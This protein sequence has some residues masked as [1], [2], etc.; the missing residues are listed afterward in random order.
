MVIVRL[1]DLFFLGF[2]TFFFLW[3]RPRRR[4]ARVVNLLKLRTNKL[5]LSPCLQHKAL[6]R[7]Y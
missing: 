1:Y 4:A 5:T 7:R 3:E 6:L 2:M